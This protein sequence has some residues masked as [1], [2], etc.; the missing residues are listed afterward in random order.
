MRVNDDV[1]LNGKI[2][3]VLPDGSFKVKFKSGQ[4]ILVTEEDINTIRPYVEPCIVDKRK[5]N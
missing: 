5:G 2:I 3:K 4:V 1:T